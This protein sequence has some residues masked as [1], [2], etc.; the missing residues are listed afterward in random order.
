MINVS[1]LRVG[2]VENRCMPYLPKYSTDP[3]QIYSICLL[4]ENIT[5]CEI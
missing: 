5:N 1:H 2:P 3:D 4:P